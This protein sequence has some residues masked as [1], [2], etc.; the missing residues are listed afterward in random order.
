MIF[1]QFR[2]IIPLPTRFGGLGIHDP[3]KEADFDY[4]DSK[5]ATAN[6]TQAIF[7]QLPSYEEDKEAQALIMKETRRKKDQ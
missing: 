4:E 2:N 7:N 3:S 1:D 5:S 6:L